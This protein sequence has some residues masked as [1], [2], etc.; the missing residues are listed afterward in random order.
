MANDRGMTEADRDRVGAAVT[1]AEAN[2]AGEIVTIFARQS[3]GYSDVALAWSALVGLLALLALAIFPHFYLGLYD[4][5]TGNWVQEWAPRQLF[6]I[7][8]WVVSL[9]FV[10]TWLLMLWRP[11]RL[12]LT[13]A[14]V[15]HRRVHARALAAFRIGAERRTTG[16]TGILIYLSM[17]ERRAEIIADQAIAAR[18]S[19]DV[20]GAALAA[21][22]VEIRAGRMADGLI[23]AIEQVGAVLAEHFPRADDDVNELPDRLIEV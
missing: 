8:A 12:W 21:M 1:A 17:A 14:P 19:A 23:A 18:V 15:R 7:A 13:P 22:L 10:G 11:L 16:R 9:K 4:R 3:D 20:W 2:S 6:E 5:V